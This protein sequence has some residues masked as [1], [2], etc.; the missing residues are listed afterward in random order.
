MLRPG[1]M[2][3]MQSGL[4]KPQALE[5][6]LGTYTPQLYVLHCSRRCRVE[7]DFWCMYIGKFVRYAYVC[8]YFG[9]G[10][11]IHT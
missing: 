3:T 7:I 9:I 1:S 5:A 8:R 2:L 4:Q 11:S 6:V 10:Y